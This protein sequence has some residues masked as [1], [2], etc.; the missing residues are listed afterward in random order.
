LARKARRT[1][2][3]GHADG[4]GLR[5]KRAMDART[6]SR[7]MAP[8][9]PVHQAL[10]MNPFRRRILAELCKRPCIS[11]NELAKAIGTSRAN[12][13]WHVERMLEAG[14]LSARR[15]CKRII[16]QP[17]NLLDED[18]IVLFFKLSDPIT[19][20]LFQQVRKVPSSSQGELAKALKVPRQV[21]AWHMNDLIKVGLVE[22]YKDGRHRRYQATPLFDDRAKRYARKAP[23]FKTLLMKRLRDDGMG[24]VVVKGLAK[25]MVIR[26][27]TGGGHAVL[28]VVTDPFK[29]ILDEG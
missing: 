16:V 5:M 6:G 18:D 7:P 24:P 28:E 26:L 25:H 21:L 1:S 13:D 22:V 27:K 12:A 23:T 19:R 15:I 14:I 3:E 2:D 20:S 10:L 29:V 9:V 8:S 11:V 4:I 17:S